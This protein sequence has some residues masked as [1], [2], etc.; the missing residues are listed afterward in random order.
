EA[1]ALSIALPSARGA[2]AYATLEPCAHTGARGPS[3]AQSLIEA[4]IARVVV[5]TMDP[6]PRTNGAGAAALRAAGVTVVMDAAGYAPA[7]T[8]QSSAPPA[9]NPPPTPATAMAAAARGAMAGWWST[10]TRGRPFVTLKLATSLDG[11]IAMADGS[12]RWITGDRARAHAHLV[13]ARCDAILVGRGT[14]DADRPALDVRLPGLS[15][16]APA[17]LLLTSSAPPAGLDGGW[18]CV[19]SPAAALALPH[20]QHI[21]VEGGA[22]AAAAFLRGGLVDQL[23]IYRAP[24]LLGRGHPALGDIGLS[25]LAD[26]HG[27]WRLQD[28]RTLGND[29]LDVYDRA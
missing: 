21:L 24:I 18:T 25:A 27:Q 16:R 20:I 13:R 10:A 26:A 23:L 19:D 5:A 29:R 3:C 12:S 28:A 15:H 4:G 8:G 7:S 6:D 2:T 14:W 22:G 9:H 17:R 11:C 1:M